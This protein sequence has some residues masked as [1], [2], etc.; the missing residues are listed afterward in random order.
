LKQSALHGFLLATAY[1]AAALLGLHWATVSG[2]GSPVWPAAGV[3]L[4]GLLLGG[5]RLWPA[6]VIARLAAGLAVGSTQPVWVEVAIA[7]GNAAAVVL[8]LLALRHWTKIDTRL[9]RLHDLIRLIAAAL[10]SAIVAATIGTSLVAL[11]GDL[12]LEAARALW[13]NWWWGNLVG[14]LT[15]APLVLSWAAWERRKPGFAI[16][17]GLLAHWSALLLAALSVGYL[18][19]LH[20]PEIYLRSW[21]AFPVLVWA[22]L[23]FHV[24]G[25]A[26]ILTI[27]TGMAI[28]G[29]TVGSWPNEPV[30]GMTEGVLLGQEFAAL[31]AVTTLVL[32]AVADERRAKAALE[33]NEKRLRESEERLRLAQQSGK[34]ATWDWQIDAGVVAWSGYPLVDTLA[35]DDGALD[36]AAFLEVV[37]PDDRDRIAEAAGAALK[38]G[39]PYEAEYRVLQADGSARWVKSR[40]ETI[41]EGDRAV[42]M[43]GISYDITARKQADAER[44]KAEDALRSLNADLERR[45][46][47]GAARLLQAQKMES[48]GQLTGGIAHDFNNLLMVVLGSL[49]Q[50]RK[51]LP[52]GD[53]RAQ[54]LVENATEGARRGAA[55]TQRL[56]A[57]ARK[58][59]LRPQPV[60]VP[61]LVRGMAD[62]LRRSLGQQ[63]RI[64]TR[65]SLGLPPALVDPHQLEMA[66]LNL[67]VNARD[68]MPEGG[69]LTVTLDERRIDDGHTLPP[70]HYV[71]VAMSDTGTGMDPETLGRATEPF[72]T[73]KG[74]GKG[75]GLGLP[76]VYGFAEQSGGLFALRSAPGEGTTAELLLPI[77]ERH[78]GEATAPEPHDVEPAPSGERLTVL[79]VDDDALVLVGA[80]D[81]IEELGHVPVLAGSAAE[82]LEVL[83][84]RQVDVVVTDQS[85]PHMTGLQLAEEIR[86]T[87]PDLP[88]VLA[89]GFVE[90][91]AEA[92]AIA[93]RL[94][95][96]FSP[97]DLAFALSEAGAE[98]R[99]IIPL[100]PRRQ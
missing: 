66:I 99:N 54:R 97:R 32:A 70:G 43:I 27:V 8:P 5:V 77:A 40:A 37:H 94:S 74:I 65:S 44:Q 90:L 39:H 91:P 23:A 87:W 61:D 82:A 78:A 2:A 36:F 29:A 34:I 24:R 58:Q 42:R 1:F 19:F 28:W 53:E 88:V 3:A 21:H 51:R 84:D 80:A 89:S 12:S 96:P 17:V 72:F 57:F 63:I 33:A 6:I 48:I 41:R 83:R 31:V 93:L 81:M 62:L 4:A 25:A 92:Q 56:L 52:P 26:V 30:F 38:T 60:D 14:M 20:D 79:L 9:T 7:F 35:T 85:M 71:S 18:I 98:R 22:A 13:M 55:L 46:E 64:E 76:M 68:A 50:L 69:L 95:K 100:R 73:T 59:D 67:A 10:G 47:D 49:D 86:K 45:I 75:T 15:V 16:A 11:A